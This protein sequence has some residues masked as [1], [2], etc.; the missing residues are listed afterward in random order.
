VPFFRE[1]EPL[2]RAVLEEGAQRRLP[3]G[4][5]ERIRHERQAFGRELNALIQQL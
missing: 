1:V 5:D 4:I 3:A 2:I